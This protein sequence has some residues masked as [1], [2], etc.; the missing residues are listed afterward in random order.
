MSGGKDISLSFSRDQSVVA[1]VADGAMKEKKDG[2]KEG[3]G[4]GVQALLQRVIV[5]GQRW[6]KMS[7]TQ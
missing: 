3:G 2:W 6:Q 4:R 5:R 7:S 1:L